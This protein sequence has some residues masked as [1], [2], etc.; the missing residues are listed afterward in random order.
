MTTQLNTKSN[1]KM[2][3]LF[4]GLAIV[5]IVVIFFTIGNTQPNENVV[6]TMGGNTTSINIMAKEK[7]QQIEDNLLEGVNSG[8]S[9]LQTSCAYFLGEMKSERAVNP[10]LKILKS[11]ETEEVRI[12]AA[13]SLTKIK[14]EKGLFAVKRRIKFDDSER[15]KRLCEI[16]YNYSQVE[17]VHNDEI[18]E[19]SYV[20]DL[21]MGYKGV[22]L[23]E[24]TSN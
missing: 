10:L 5:A 4:G 15:V 2:I 18:A 13:L 22:R 16:F 24:F 21:N 12:M 7:F 14:S 23:S 20:V 8:N 1:N 3:A 6:G 17:G 9:G 19:P 11:G